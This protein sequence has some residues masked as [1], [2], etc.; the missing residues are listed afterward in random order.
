MWA[1]C[2]SSAERVGVQWVSWL[3]EEWLQSCWQWGW[4]MGIVMIAYA[5]GLQM[6]HMTPGSPRYAEGE[7]TN[8]INVSS[9]MQLYRT[10]WSHTFSHHLPQSTTT[11]NNCLVI[12]CLT[13][14]TLLSLHFT[15]FSR[16]LSSSLPSRCHSPTASY[17]LLSTL[18]SSIFHRPSPPTACHLR[19]LLHAPTRRV[20]H[21]RV[22]PRSGPCQAGDGDI[23][24]IGLLYLIFVCFSSFSC[25]LALPPFCSLSHSSLS[26]GHRSPLLSFLALC[27]LSGLFLYLQIEYQRFAYNTMQFVASRT[28]IFLTFRS[29]FPP[30]HAHCCL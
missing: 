18:D 19:S 20:C 22:G 26:I 25:I 24:V 30:F 28:P 23:M 11:I 14:I 16:L 7:P 6:N 12:A 4:N 13:L 8:P 10:T 15:S 1:I 3:L 21:A 17:L 27:P 5:L 2:V 29:L 9:P